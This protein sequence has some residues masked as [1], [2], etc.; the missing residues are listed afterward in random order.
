MLRR[1]RETAPAGLVP[2]AWTFATAAHLELLAV[3][4]VLAGHVV[5]DVLLLAFAVL[6]WDDMRDHLVL[7]AWL[8][9][10][11]VGFGVTLVGTY[12]LAVGDESLARLTVLGW[13]LLPALALLYTGRVLPAAERASLYTLGG[14]LSGVGAVAFAVGVAPVAAL[15]AV[16]VGQTLGILVAVVEY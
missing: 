4:T 13:M 1:L 10:I 2:L 8:G 14:A 12:A 6:S 3:R 9:V 11:V 16:G 7:R 5:M 15:V